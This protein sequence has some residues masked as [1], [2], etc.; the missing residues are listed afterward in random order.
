MIELHHVSKTLPSGGRPLTILH[1]LDISIPA[2]QFL[3]VMGPSGSGKSTLLGLIAGLDT[4]STGEIRVN[5]QVLTRMNEDELARFRG[6]TIGFIFQ[7]F[8]LIPTLTAL[9]NV[10]VPLEI[11]RSREA[12][13]RGGRLLELVGLTE[14][15]GHYPA[16]LS[17]GEQQR[18]GIARAFAC[19]PA[20]LLADEPTGNLDSATGAQVLGLLE[21]LHREQGTTVVLV[22]HDAEVAAR[23][24]RIIQ[25]RDGRIVDDHMN[26]GGAAR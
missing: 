4:P 13:A 5:G 18:V 20:V 19:A 25:L 1:P 11:A 26:N 8:Q 3:T 15:A 14:R 12:R 6:R 24:Q 22:T 16:Q 23:A 9:E 2:G 10:M 17:G 21:R 7:T